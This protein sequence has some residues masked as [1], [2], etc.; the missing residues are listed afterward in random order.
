MPEPSFASETPTFKTIFYS[1]TVLS[2]SQQITVSPQPTTESFYYST[3]HISTTVQAT[4][5]V[6]IPTSE[7][8]RGCS[9]I[10]RASEVVAWVLVVV[11]IIL[12][13]VTLTVYTIV[14]VVYRQRH[15]RQF[16]L[17]AP[18]YEMEGNP[19]YEATQVTLTM[20]SEMEPRYEAL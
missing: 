9:G 1:K 11:L 2:G 10:V 17:Q 19:C 6:H 13:T 4:L 5:S 16:D 8:E 20:A 7:E 12:L 15:M 14:L 3:P 18:V